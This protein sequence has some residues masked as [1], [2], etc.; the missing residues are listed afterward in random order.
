[1]RT[2]SNINTNQHGPTIMKVCFNQGYF[3]SQTDTSHLAPL[4]GLPTPLMWR[5]AL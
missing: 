4:F 3:G 5:D 2:A 1:L